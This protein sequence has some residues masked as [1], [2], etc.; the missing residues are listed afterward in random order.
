MAYS[1]TRSSNLDY[2]RNN[3]DDDYRPQPAPST[4]DKPKSNRRIFVGDYYEDFKSKFISNTIST[5]KYNFISFLPKFLFEQFRRYANIFFLTIGLL[6]QIP[7]VS[8][9]GRYVTIVPFMTILT[10]SAIKEL[11]E[12]VKRHQADDKVNMGKTLVFDRHLRRFVEKHWKDVVVGDIIRTENGMFFASDMILLAS[13]EPQGM[14]YIETS[15]L[16]GETNLK[17]RSAI[18]LTFDL[19]N[20][21]NLSGFTGEVHCEEPN[22]NL[23]EFNGN[24]S[25]NGSDFKPLSPTA[26]LLRGAKLM[27]TKWVH[28]VVVY[29]GHETKLLMNSNRAPLKRS[30][31][32]KITNY[33]II[34][35]FVILIVISVASA[36]SN[37]VLSFNG[38]HHTYIE[39]RD[40]EHSKPLAG[41][42]SFFLDL[43]TFIILYNNLIPISLQVSLE[44]VKFTQ[45]IVE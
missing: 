27:N 42:S 36:V 15:N 21:E 43:L 41:A 20:D 38:E 39:S 45:V 30:N 25:V 16:D 28:G 31:I 24:I 34:F 17:I 29:T 5:A 32:D 11:I 9:T 8:P 37:L 2:R 1:G 13:S 3:D 40:G 23:Y 4:A 19:D 10:L 33:Q 26:V 14:C 7:D 22:R 12:D 18:P 35:L 6:Q 44:F